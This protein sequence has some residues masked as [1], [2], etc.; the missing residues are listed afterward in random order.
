[1]V[2]GTN[3]KEQNTPLS[4]CLWT[5]PN[6]TLMRVSAVFVTPVAAAVSK[7]GHLSEKVQAVFQGLFW[8]RVHQHKQCMGLCI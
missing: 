6:W 7:K 3:S 2:A 8:Q 1:M 5:R 4:I